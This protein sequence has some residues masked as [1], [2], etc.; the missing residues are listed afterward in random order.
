M[1]IG[2]AAVLQGL[3]W[4]LLWP[5]VSFLLVAAA[6]SGLGPCMFGKRTSGQI[7]WWALLLLLPFFFLAWSVWHLQRL[8]SK[9]DCWNEVAPGL[10][11]GRRSFASELPPGVGLVVDLTSEFRA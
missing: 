4:L 9:E 5:A 1:L 11:L 10:F 3:A 7:A 6:Y 2:Y 8:F